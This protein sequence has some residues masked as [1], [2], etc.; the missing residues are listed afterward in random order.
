MTLRPIL[1][2][3]PPAHLV[4]AALGPPQTHFGIRAAERGIVSIPGDALRHA[5]A[6]AIGHKR[7]DLVEELFVK[8]G[9]LGPVTVCRILLPE[10]PFYPLVGQT[11][12]P[13]TIYDPPR[14]RQMRDTRRQRIRRLGRGAG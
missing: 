10:G 5:V 9:R 13:V 12:N 2:A 1:E 3:Q 14:Y 11:G 4:L 6:W 7:D 8:A